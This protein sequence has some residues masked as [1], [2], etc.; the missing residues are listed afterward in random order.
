MTN[1]YPPR[2][3]QRCEN[4]FFAVLYGLIGELDAE[5]TQYCE[6]IECRRCAPPASIGLAGTI[7]F[8]CHWP[9]VD[10][11]DWCGDWSPKEAQ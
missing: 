3:E 1:P 2:R 6:V 10:A 5:D 11:L 4:C 7:T 9:E 8:T